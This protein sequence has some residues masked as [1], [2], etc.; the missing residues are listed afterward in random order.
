M[1]NAHVHGQIEYLRLARD[2]GSESDIRRQWS[3]M[4][5]GAFVPQ[6]PRGARG[7]PT[8]VTTCRGRAV[9]SCVEPGEKS[10][11]S[12]VHSLRFSFLRAHCGIFYLEVWKYGQEALGNE[13]LNAARDYVPMRYLDRI[14]DRTTQGAGDLVSPTE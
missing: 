2:R 7:S 10:R 1:N 9:P 3:P 5:A 4:V 6:Y 12:C 13:C 8:R 11:F 14:F